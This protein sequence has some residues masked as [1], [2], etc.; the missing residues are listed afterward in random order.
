MDNKNTKI[1]SLDAE[2]D[3][4]YGHAFAIGVTVRQDSQEIASFQGRVPDEFVTNSWVKDHV[5]PALGDM[6]ITHQTPEELEE[7]FWTFWQSQ[8]QE[9][10][11]IAHCGSPVE[12]GLFRRCVEKD[13]ANRMF[14]GPYPCLHDVGTLLLFKGFDPSSVDGYLRSKNIEVPFCGATHHPMYDAVAAAI[15]WEDLNK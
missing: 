6:E 8:K 13:L 15:V 9:V 3:G 14:A 12:T 10:T 4:L 11:V 7:D 5:L 1:F 2:V